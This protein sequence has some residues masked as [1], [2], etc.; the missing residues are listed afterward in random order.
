M[1]LPKGWARRGKYWLEH[2][3]AMKDHVACAKR[4]QPSPGLLDF[5]RLAQAIENDIVS[6]A[7]KVF[8]DSETNAAGRTGD[9]N[10]FHGNI[11]S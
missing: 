1:S 10:G 11:L 5:V 6:G 8:G 9:D 7:R 2:V 3:G 4:G